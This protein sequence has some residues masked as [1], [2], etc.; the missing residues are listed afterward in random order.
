MIRSVIYPFYLAVPLYLLQITGLDSPWA[1]IHCPKLA[2]LAL[3]L[4]SDLFMW[5]IGKLTIGK[6]AARVSMIIMAMSAVYNENQIRC[7]TN[8]VE[9]MF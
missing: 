7:F 9:T 1:V 6:N 5:R 3:V 4:I 2:H 8:S